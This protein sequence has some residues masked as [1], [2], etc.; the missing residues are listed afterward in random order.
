MSSLE[1]K[2]SDIMK[3]IYNKNTMDLS[4]LQ[5]F[6][7][8]FFMNITHYDLVK[9]TLSKKISAKLNHEL[10][11]TVGQCFKDT[12]A[13]GKKQA[14]KISSHVAKHAN[15]DCKEAE[16][17]KQLDLLDTQRKETLPLLQKD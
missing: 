10:L 3:E 1:A 16:L 9:S 14:A 13:L 7:K 11:T 17:K 2:A 4:A 5:A 15:I 8:T 6:S 12:E